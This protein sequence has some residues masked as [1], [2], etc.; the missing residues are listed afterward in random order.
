MQVHFSATEGASATVAAS[1]APDEEARKGANRLLEL[2]QTAGAAPF[3]DEVSEAYI[4]LPTDSGGTKTLRVRTREC[5]TWLAHLAW[6]VDGKA[7]AA[8]A[9]DGAVTVLEAEA[10]HSPGTERRALSVRTCWHDDGIW[11]DLGGPDWQAPRVTPDGWGIEP[12]PALFRRYGHM[13]PQVTPQP[14]GDLA[15]VLDY[16]HLRDD[17]GALLL[18]WLVA[19]LVPDIPHPALVLHGPAGAAKT[20]TM[21]VLRR[22]IDPSAT[23]TLSMPHDLRE[24]VQ[25]LAHHYVW[26]ADNVDRLSAEESDAL[27]RAVTGDA[28][29]KRALY[30]DDDDHVYRYRRVLML[31]GVSCVAQRPDLLDRSILLGLEPV[32]PHERREEAEYWRAFERDR[33]FILGGLLDALSAAMAIRPEVR[34]RE[35]PRMADFAAWG[36]AAAEALGIGGDAF[37][38]AYAANVRRQSDEALSAH[39]IGQALRSLLADRDE[40]RGSPAELLTALEA[41]AEQERIDTRARGWPKAT[42]VLRRRIVEVQH[43]LMAEG[44]TV[45][46]RDEAGHANKREWIIRRKHSQDS[47]DSQPYSDGS[48]GASATASAS[49]AVGGSAREA[50]AKD[51]RSESTNDGHLGY[52]ASAASAASATAGGR[53]SRA[54]GYRRD[55][56]IPDGEGLTP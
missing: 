42:H 47:Q 50:L 45:D 43:S 35:H 19:A 55:L 32:A 49:E 34:L 38:T 6:T 51:S 33:P 13:A 28:A 26:P 21:R 20:T 16:L 40:W 9:L 23:E 36:Y 56:V 24:L 18:P 39:P 8:A 41:V 12:A 30:T 53:R 27:C 15:A 54:G 25:S 5:R 17:L 44:W 37:L 48:L 10:L 1:Q 46:L 29:T 14:G 7:A 3:T 22:L 11:V 31:S 2:T 4:A 52:R